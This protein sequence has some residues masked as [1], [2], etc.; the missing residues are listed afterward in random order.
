M[1]LFNVIKSEL[2]KLKKDTMFY[3]GTLITMLVPVLVIIKDKAISTPPKAALDWVM[4]CCLVDFLS[5][6]YLVDLLLQI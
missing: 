1:D 3:S 5:Y 4:I 2:L 6:L